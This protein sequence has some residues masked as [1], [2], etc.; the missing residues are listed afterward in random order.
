MYRSLNANLV[1][2][3]DHVGERREVGKGVG[4]DIEERL[5]WRNKTPFSPPTNTHPPTHPLTLPCD[6]LSQ[7]VL[8][9]ARQPGGNDCEAERC[10]MKVETLVIII[11]FFGLVTGVMPVTV[12]IR[13]LSACVHLFKFFSKK[14]SFISGLS[15]GRHLSRVVQNSKC[16]SNVSSIRSVTRRCNP[17][18]GVCLD[19]AGDDVS[20]CLWA[21]SLPSP[22]CVC[23]WPA[24]VTFGLG[25]TVVFLA[26]LDK[27]FSPQLNDRNG[28]GMCLQAFLVFLGA[29]PDCI[30]GPGHTHRL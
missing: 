19:R 29:G 12:R 13:S 1:P 22:D 6:K 18:L 27:Q 24:G 8:Y 14:G 16:F 4:R 26:G 23:L 30:T 10:L 25:G 15:V 9:S 2:L 21:L 17:P 7:Q 11:V 20:T 3:A 28:F 5:A